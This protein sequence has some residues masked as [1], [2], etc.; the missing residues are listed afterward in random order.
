MISLAI[1][2]LACDAENMAERARSVAENAPG[3]FFVDSTCIDCDTCRQL[4][5][6]TFADA[7]T[8]SYV[9]LQPRDVSETRAALR[10]LVACPSASIGATDMRGAA[11][12]ADDFPLAL[13]LPIRGRGSAASLFWSISPGWLPRIPNRQSAKIGT[14]EGARQALSCGDCHVGHRSPPPCSCGR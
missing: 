10:A 12:A 9:H 1:A 13:L 6:A 4:A 3:S 5:P 8:H 2:S 7:G 11:L 14:E